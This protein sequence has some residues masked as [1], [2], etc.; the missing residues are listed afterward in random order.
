MTLCRVNLPS[1]SWFCDYVILSPCASYG[2]GFGHTNL[3]TQT[4]VQFLGRLYFEK[5]FVMVTFFFLDYQLIF[6]VVPTFLVAVMSLYQNSLSPSTVHKASVETSLIYAVTL[7][8]SMH[9]MSVCAVNCISLLIWGFLFVT[10]SLQ[11]HHVGCFVYCYGQ[12]SKPVESR[13]TYRP[14]TG[15]W[16]CV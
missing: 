16:D 3:Q 12:R 14:Q 11:N 7:L 1:L 10:G 9:W 15:L 13:W 2:C 6:T 4:C 8:H 5:R